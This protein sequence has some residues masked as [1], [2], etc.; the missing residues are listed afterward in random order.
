MKV[1]KRILLFI[2]HL[3]KIVTCFILIVGTFYYGYNY[4]NKLFR[5]PEVSYGDSFH[6]VK[7]DSVDVLVLGSSHAQYS[8]SPTFFYEDS[9]L[10]SYVL[11]SA[12]QPL[13][14]SYQ[15]L[16]EALKSQDPSLVVLEVY[17]A[18]LDEEEVS[19]S[20]YVL[21][22]YQMTGEEKY[23]TIDFLPEDKRD[24]Y[25]N[26]FLNNHNNWRTLDSLD[27]LFIKDT[28]VDPL[29][30]YVENYVYLPAENYWYSNKYSSDI[31]TSLRD[32]DLKAL[33]D[34]YSLCQSENINLLLYM[35][36]MDNVTQLGQSLRHKVWDW[37][38]ENGVPYLD[39]LEND[40][41]L[42][43]RSVIHHDGYHAFINGASYITDYLADYISNNYSFNHNGN[44][45]LDNLY[46]QNAGY[47]S[48][49]ALNNEYNPS[50]YM[51][52]LISYPYTVLVKYSGSYEDSMIKDYL[53][54]MGISINEGESFYGIVR[55]GELIASNNGYLEY[56]LDGNSIKIDD[57]NITYNDTNI[58]CNDLLTFVLIDKN[59]NGHSKKVVDYLDGRAWEFGHDFYYN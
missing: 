24:T 40:E 21:A 16:R 23:N 14:V 22:E 54:K 39:L 53:S 52:R 31:D 8:F 33:N 9:G 41:Q 46:I 49:E 4:L 57:Y 19:D 36:P 1:F 26:E 45:Y 12:F 55:N 29:F 7:E 27:S 38:N 3:I 20:R 15:M 43:I 11:G 10:Y 32:D 47:L 28:S 17:T 37:A 13:K 48:I 25:K 56:D 58:E 6:N 42:D 34:I 35:V 50:K 30:G 2:W 59:Y 5:T 51:Q 18:T 44:P